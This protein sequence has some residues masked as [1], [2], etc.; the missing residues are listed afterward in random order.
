MARFID[1]SLVVSGTIYADS[2]VLDGQTV[3]ED[4][5]GRLILLDGGVSSDK[6]ALKAHGDVLSV[7]GATA[8]SSGRFAL[9]DIVQG[10]KYIIDGVGGFDFVTQMNA[11]ANTVGTEFYASR[12]G[13]AADEAAFPGAYVKPG[14]AAAC[15]LN[16]GTPIDA[17]AILVW[18]FAQG[19]T[20]ATAR[21]SV[22]VRRINGTLWEGGVADPETTG[23]A[24]EVYDAYLEVVYRPP[25]AA[26]YDF[27]VSGG[28]AG[29]PLHTLKQALLT[30]AEYSASVQYMRDEMGAQADFPTAQLEIGIVGDADHDSQ[31]V[32]EWYGNED[33]NTGSGDI[34]A[35]GSM[36]LI[37]L[38][39]V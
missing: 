34:S 19:Y 4:G 13:T 36:S 21:W 15:V 29:V 7:H 33:N 38:K 25:D 14:W 12:D 26:G 22:R 18:S 24:Q 3:G 20:A 16:V 30:S 11:A 28:G 35:L 31:I 6:I 5:E 1:G 10:Q 39:R 37:M 23:R 32:L 27:Y 17:S 2:L 8:L 9:D